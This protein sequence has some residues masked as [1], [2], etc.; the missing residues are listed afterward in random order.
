M[1]K[2][3][4]RTEILGR[5]KAQIEAKQS[6]LVVGAGNGLV[7]R[8]AEQAGADL[9]VVYNS[10]YFRLNGHP[11]MVGNLPVGDANEIMLRLGERAVIPATK[12]IPVVGGAYGV[13]PT[14]DMDRLLEQI[15]GVGFSGII[16]FPT[17]GRIDGQYRKDLEAAGLGFC[18]EADMVRRARDKDMFTMAYVYS[19]EDTRMMVEAGVDVIVG[20]C[21]LTAGGDV[22][23][24]NAMPL[25]NAVSTLKTLFEAAKSARE[26]IILLSHGGPISSPEDAEYVNFHTDAVGFVAAS[27]VERIPIEET[28]KSACRSFKSIKVQ[29]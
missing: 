21:G 15:S 12:D 2:R 24:L 18:R 3:F 29:R 4:T 26:D 10:G 20:H 7:A 6:I 8:C 19:P 22:G 9:V 14:R 27:S 5:L 1:S 28:L 23:S 25:D 13:D 11:S 17:V 16:N